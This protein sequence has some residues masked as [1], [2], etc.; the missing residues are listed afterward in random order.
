[1]ILNK[2]KSNI[3]NPECELISEYIKNLIEKENKIS[4][5]NNFKEKEIIDLDILKEI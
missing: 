5:E 1:M 2:M 3:L 4:N